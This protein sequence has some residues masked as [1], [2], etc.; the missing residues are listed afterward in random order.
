MECIFC[1]ILQGN[2]EASFI[3]RDEAVSAFMDINPVNDGHVLIVPN[4]HFA[5]FSDID[6][7]ILEKLINVSQRILKAIEASHLPCDGAN[8]FISD[9]EA[10]GQDVPHTHMHIVPRLKDDKQKAGFIHSTQNQVNR[11]Y[12]SKIAGLIKYQLK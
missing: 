11:E 6:P 9:G 3:Y 5:R 4:T 12:L 2:K 1:E 7:K 10:A 8:F